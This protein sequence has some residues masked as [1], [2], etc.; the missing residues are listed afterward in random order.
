MGFSLF[1]SLGNQA[2]I[3][4]AD[5]LSAVARD[6]ETRVIVGYIEGVADGRRFFETLRD[7][8]AV[9]PVVLLKAGR[10]VEGARAVSSHTGRAGG[11]RPRLRRRGQAGR[12]GAGRHASRSCSTWRAGW[13]ASPCPVVGVCSS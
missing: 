10:S 9:K 4:E 12:G 3:T 7:A 2:D 11:L 13:R 6:D 8:A 5:V 1:A